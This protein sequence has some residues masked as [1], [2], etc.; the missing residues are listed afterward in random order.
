MKTDALTP[1]QR[2]CLI[3]ETETAVFLVHQGLVALNETGAGNDRYHLPLKLLS[4]GFERLLKL[5]ICL[6][7][8][9]LNG[10]LPD[11]SSFTRGKQGHDLDRLLQQVL[12]ICR[13][14]GDAEDREATRSDADFL[15]SNEDLKR[16]VR[17]LSDFGKAGRYFNLDL[18]LTGELCGE[19]P[20]NLF[21]CFY[22][23]MLRRRP[24]WLKKVEAQE[25][26]AVYDELNRD[27]IA[28]LQR[29][30]RALCRMFTL[31][32]LGELGRSLT[33]QIQQFLFLADDELGRLE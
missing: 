29:F 19:D 12:R 18:L 26:G 16:V 11:S 3:R 22:D 7:R 10:A 2:L 17:L 30:A 1:R 32:P 15:E 27:M 31:G 6:G 33:G 8:L 24:D 13:E 9:E 23:E 21:D 5:V 4:G 28:L 25:L 14:S 20:E